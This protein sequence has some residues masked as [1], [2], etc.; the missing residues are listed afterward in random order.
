MNA[1]SNKSNDN[2]C[3]RTDVGKTL[4]KNNVNTVDV[5]KE[6]NNVVNKDEMTQV[7]DII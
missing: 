4:L 3:E 7:N 5:E 2:K 1:S 6:N